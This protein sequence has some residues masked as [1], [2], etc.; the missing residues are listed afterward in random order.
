MNKLRIKLIDLAI[1]NDSKPTFPL[2]AGTMYACIVY[3][4]VHGIRILSIAGFSALGDVHNKTEFLVSE[5]IDRWQIRK[6]SHRKWWDAFVNGVWNLN[7][8]HVGWIYRPKVPVF[9]TRQLLASQL[10]S[11]VWSL[12]WENYMFAHGSYVLHSRCILLRA[13]CDETLDWVENKPEW[14]L[15]CLAKTFRS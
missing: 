10:I 14:S 8:P 12:L 11:T 7:H 3:V 13:H 5:F 2:H 6:C 4:C 15:S 9:A 1:L